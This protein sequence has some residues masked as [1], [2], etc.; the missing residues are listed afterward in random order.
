[1]ESGSGKM[2]QWLIKKGIAKTDQQAQIILIIF[3]IICFIGTM[4]FINK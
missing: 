3:I 2:G 4:Y 1:M